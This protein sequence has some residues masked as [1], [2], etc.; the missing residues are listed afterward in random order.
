MMRPGWAGSPCGCPARLGARS[1]WTRMSRNTRALP[2][3]TPCCRSRTRT[4]RCPSLWNGLAASTARIRVTT[5]ASLWAVFGPR[6]APAVSHSRGPW[7]TRSTAAPATPHAERIPLPRRRTVAPAHFRSLRR[8]SP[9][10]FFEQVLGEI[11]AHRHLLDLRLQSPH[12]A[13]L[14]I[15]PVALQPLLATLQ[16]HPP[17]LFE[18]VHRDLTLAG[19]LVDRLAPDEPGYD[20]HLRCA[21]HRSGRSSARCVVIVVSVTGQLLLC[22]VSRETGTA[23]TG[24][25][26]NS[27]RRGVSPSSSGARAPECASSSTP[28]PSRT[29]D[30]TARDPR[31]IPCVGGSSSSPS[32][33][34]LATLQRLAPLATAFV[35][36]NSWSGRLSRAAGRV[37]RDPG[38][39]AGYQGGQRSTRRR[40]DR[41]RH[42]QTDPG[43]DSSSPVWSMT[44]T[45]T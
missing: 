43:L 41:R 25:S 6:F 26:C 33:P 27:C 28:L 24:T 7:R 34:T 9:N 37:L 18:L 29:L 21:L 12:L 15:K 31:G 19:D 2:A 22:P 44:P 20:L 39:T 38:R 4:L 17:P 32:V 5:S 3:C 45:P 13:R 36:A 1:P 11:E 23:P 35:Q 30:G 14:G 40:Q 16:E 10:S 8:S 42:R